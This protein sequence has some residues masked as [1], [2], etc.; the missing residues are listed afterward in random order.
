MGRVCRVV[1]AC[2][3]M[4]A[5][6]ACATVS[7]TPMESQSKKRDPRLARLY[8]IWPRSG[9]FKTGT[10][11][12]KV[13]GQVIGKIAPDSYLF[14]DRPRGS[15]TLKVEPPADFVYFETDVQVAAGGT[16]YYAITMK[17]AYVPLSTGG[18]V[19]LSHRN[20]GTPLAPKSAGMSFATYK[21]SSL[22]AATAA[23]E[24]AEL[25]AQ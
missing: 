23:A 3:V 16:Y 6:S 9:M 11:D 12:I 17:T 4:F 18:T 22:D 1:M 15:Y 25:D 10:L 20:P 21:F 5:L 8:F 2:I 24:M 13:D 19:A 14:I 7:T